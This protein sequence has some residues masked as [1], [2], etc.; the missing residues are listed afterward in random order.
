MLQ[1]GPALSPQQYNGAPTLM[2]SLLDGT[3]RCRCTT[4]AS[5][6]LICK[7]MAT[8]GQRHCHPQRR[9]HLRATGRTFLF[10]SPPIEPTAEVRCKVTWQE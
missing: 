1:H 6:A 10:F 5:A 7:G 4:S 9:K 3:P 8:I 2:Y